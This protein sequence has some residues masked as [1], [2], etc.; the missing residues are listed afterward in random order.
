VPAFPKF[1]WF[2]LGWLA[3][4]FP[5][6]W[7]T[8]G[9]ENFF[10]LCDLA[11]FVAVWGLWTGRP[12]L[13]SSQAVSMLFVGVL[14][15]ADLVSYGIFGWHIFGGTAYFWD[16]QYPLWVRLLS[17]Y[18]IGLPV[19]MVWGLGHTGY[20]ARGWQLQSALALI[21]TF[22]SRLGSPEKNLNF[23]F[24]EP[25]FNQQ[26]GPAPVHLLIVSSLLIA[27]IYFPTHLLLSRWLPP[28]PAR[29]S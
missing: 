26:W 9:F 20:D 11:V 25:L 27:L 1:R 22:A 3:V 28:C 23:A 18:H 14:W 13:L 15:V 7:H 17:L 4:W 21:V 16:P 2:A 8:W 6:Y 5:A 10:L 29:Q 19:A 24:R 12:L